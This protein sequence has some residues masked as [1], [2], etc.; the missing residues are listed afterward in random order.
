MTTPSDGADPARRIAQLVR[1]LRQAEEELQALAGGQL[2]AVVSEDAA[3]YLLR[4]AQ[5]R[6]R[7]SEAAQRA[8]AETQIAILN[9]LPAHIAL[10]DANGVIVVVNEAWRRFASA[11]V[12]QGTDF[13]VGQNYLSVCEGADGECAE[14]ARAVALG[15][16]R[17][18]RGEL[19]VFTLE[20]PC[21]SPTEKRWFRLMVTPLSE[22]PGTGAV[23][24]HVNVTDRRLAEEVLRQQE[25]EQRRL[26][27]ELTAEAQRLHDSQA[28]A[29]VGSWE[30]DLS[31]LEVS[32][33]EETFRILETSPD[34]LAPTHQRFLERVHPDDRQKV[35]DAFRRSSVGPGPLV[36]EHR[37]LL[38]GGRIKHVELRG[39]VFTDAAGTPVRAVGTCQDVTARTVADELVRMRARQQ[40]TIARIGFEAT[41]ATTLQAFLDF[42]TRATAET[43]QVE[44]CKVLQLAPDESQLRL[45]SGVGWEPG[46]IGVATVG[47]GVE[48]QAGWTLRSGG[49]VYVN[50]FAE[51]TR[52]TAPPLLRQHDVVSGLSVKITPGDRPWGVLG[53]HCRTARRFNDVDA[54]F[55]Q[56]VAA[57]LAL[58]IERLA[59][60][61]TLA[62]SEARMRDAQR[63]AHL[64]NWELDLT[65]DELI[66][67][68]EV[69]RI[70][71]V[72]PSAFACTYESFLARV[73]PD[74]RDAV[75]AAQTGALSGRGPLEIEH[76]IIRPDGAIRHVRERAELIHDESGRPVALSGTVLDTTDL[77]A[78]QAQAERMNALLSEAQQIADM[79][80]WEV[81]LTTGRLVWAEETCR[82]FGVPPE[83]C[84]GTFES[85]ERLI[86][87]QDRAALKAIHARITPEAPLLEAEYRIRRPDGEVRWMFERGRVT[88]DAAGRAIR[89]LGVVMDVTERKR[90]E[91]DVRESEERF[92]LMVEGSEQ[93]LFYTHDLNH[94]FEYLSP[95]TRDV[96]GYEP[97]DLVGKPWDVLVSADDPL[98]ADAR[99]ITARTL[100]D[101]NPG[102]SSPFIVRHKDGRA[103][104]SKFWKARAFA[105]GRSSASRGSPATSPSARPHGSLLQRASG[106][107]A[108]WSK[109]PTTSS[110]PWTSRGASRSSTRRR[111]RYSGANR[112]R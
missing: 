20:Y 59:V 66:W 52:F 70:F 14:E 30:M 63:I 82:L 77:R 24:M 83:E 11:N 54:D 16:R 4:A 44:L 26:A 38:D 15:I 55:M 3:P 21:H 8:Q 78:A 58:V 36:L 92:R 25:Q 100:R 112:R 27:E 47:V 102:P 87:P 60:Q 50:D 41:R 80:S 53:A 111:G 99:A 79:G 31:T 33:T 71:G 62:R 93:V 107:I 32:W 95:S 67:S 69:F 72:D 48:S 42:A 76:R 12:L 57:L 29:N 73:H 86:L 45:V 68:E 23:V 10:L 101:G 2:D 56:A 90:A 34:Q 1:S 109:R 88:F 94:R 61:H 18:L 9:A 37:L 5:E 46:L 81:D 13:F 84:G 103:W 22:A 91:A 65:K 110:G 35:D 17:V 104:C 98:R 64:G 75:Q 85:F 51:E 7:V 40:E 106:S 105:T 74:D 89:R 97:G 6:L 49:A 108:T 43:L 96:L 19:E 28:A 39:Q